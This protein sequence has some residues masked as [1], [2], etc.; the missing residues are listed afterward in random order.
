[1][2]VK[3]LIRT[4]VTS[5]ATIIGI[6]AVSEYLI[7]LLWWNMAPH[8]MGANVGYLTQHELDAYPALASAAVIFRRWAAAIRFIASFWLAAWHQWQ[9]NFYRMP[10]G[11][12]WVSQYWLYVWSGEQT[13]PDKTEAVFLYPEDVVS[14]RGPP[15][16]QKKCSHV[17]SGQ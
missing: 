17:L 7:P 11:W 15:G 3:P 9:H 16:S 1:M 13:L 12:G 5:T 6:V 2:P 10:G 8:W 4:I 14:H